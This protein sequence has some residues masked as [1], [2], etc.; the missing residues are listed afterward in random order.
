VLGS[1]VTTVTDGSVV[2]GNGSA[3]DARTGTVSVGASGAE[4]QIINVAAG[5][6]AADSTDAVNGSQLRGVALSLS[7]SL[8]GGAT[9]NVDGSLTAPTYTIDGAD[10]DNVGAALEAVEALASGAGDP[11]AVIYDDASRNLITL[12]GDSGATRISNVADAQDDDDAVNLGQLTDAI[13]SVGGA[14]F[15]EVAAAFGGGATWSGG[16]WTGP[17]Y[18]I[19]SHDYANVGG[20]F[21]AVDDALDGLLGRVE[22]LEDLPPGGGAPGLSAY[23]VAV[24]NGF[25]GTQT[26]WLASLVGAPGA[27]GPEGP[28]GAEGP[29]GPQ[30]D[31]GAQGPQGD[32]G[33]QGPQGDTGAQG[34]QGD[35]GP[36]GPQGDTGAQGPQGDA[37][38]QGPQGD[39][40]A[41]GPQGDA[42]AQGPQ[43]DTGAQGPQG[44]AGPQ[45]AQGDTGAQGPQGEQGP[46]GPQGPAGVD[47]A[48]G[49]SAYQV[50]ANNGFAGTEAEWLRS[51]SGCGLG[52]MDTA[53]QCGPGAE[54]QSDGSVAIGANAIAASSV[55][56]GAGSQALGT[57]TTAL[58]DSA[59][60]SGNFAVAVGNNAQATADDS[61]AIG[62][63]SVAGEANTVS[64]GSAGNERRITNVAAGSNATDA[65]NLN[66]MLTGDQQTLAAARSY[67]DG[68]FTELR[69][70]IDDLDASVTQDLRALRGRMDRI[71]A[72]GAAQVQAS[73]AASALKGDTRLALGIG[74][75][76]GS[77]AMAIGL[78]QRVNDHSM[79]T[80][81]GSFSGSEN[82]VGVGFGVSW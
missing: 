1:N 77:E 62:N 43:G 32:A 18:S 22:A 69:I 79:L 27:Q 21:D 33:P 59:V 15:T 49:L 57:N 52:T 45:G 19:Q 13:A 66:Q 73:A 72:I 20:A 74:N 50:A 29:Q 2:L 3:S 14:D 75:M 4:R 76:G 7:N 12:Q 8:G 60:A 58:G 31:T 54:A 56:V 34:P 64:V 40:G 68:R 23:E 38:P 17:T 65:V 71:G 42:G 35:A 6:L 10:F 24:N 5:S 41:Q 78:Q 30:G 44:D 82:S 63:G 70:A 47:G 55:A 39:T 11:L 36:Q 46:A 51:M 61:V 26:E 81:G 9:V 53:I 25:V 67:T 16:S 37:G 80:F 28:S 48:D